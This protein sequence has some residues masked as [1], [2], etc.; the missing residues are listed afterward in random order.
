MKIR[1]VR[2]D[3]FP[4]GRRQTDM[5]KPTVVFLNVAKAPVSCSYEAA[6]INDYGLGQSGGRA[7]NALQNLSS[8]PILSG[9]IRTPRSTSSY[10][11]PQNPVG[12]LCSVTDYKA[13]NQ[14]RWS[15]Q[16]QL[17]QVMWIPLLQKNSSATKRCQSTTA[18]SGRDVCFENYKGN[19]LILNYFLYCTYNVNRHHANQNVGQ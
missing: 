11:L 17:N 2:A 3:F 12:S 16:L 8:L 14:V 5:T 18:P 9:K 6:I 7:H 19:Y 10:L 4:C 13:N 15:G 1:P